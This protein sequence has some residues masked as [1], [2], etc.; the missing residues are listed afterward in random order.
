M[1]AHSK[2]RLASRQPSAP[3]APIKA[4]TAGRPVLVILRGGILA[5]WPAMEGEGLKGT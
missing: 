4:G 5:R 2:T 1:R 3:A